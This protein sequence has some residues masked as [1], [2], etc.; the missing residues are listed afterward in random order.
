MRN[1]EKHIASQKLLTL[2]LESQT[3]AWPR[4]YTENQQKIIESFLLRRCR[5]F[6]LKL[7]FIFAIC[8]NMHENIRLHLMIINYTQLLG[9]LI[10]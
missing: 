4:R 5:T 9:E 10:I 7:S 2:G 8:L 6:L 1:G 3:L